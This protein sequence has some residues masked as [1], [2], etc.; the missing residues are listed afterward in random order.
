MN[1]MNTVISVLPFFDYEKRAQYVQDSAGEHGQ[2][3]TSFESFF[4][5]TNPNTK[6]I[7]RRKKTITIN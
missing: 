5:K 1:A 4:L 3:F 2:Y 6:L 7:N